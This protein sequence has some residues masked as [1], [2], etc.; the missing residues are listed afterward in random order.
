MIRHWWRTRKIFPTKQAKVLLPAVW[1]PAGVSAPLAGGGEGRLSP[2]GGHPLSSGLCVIAC[3]LCKWRMKTTGCFLFLP[4]NPWTQ[5]TYGSACAGD[6]KERLTL[7]LTA[8]KNQCFSRC[9]LKGT[10]LLREQST[11]RGECRHHASGRSWGLHH[12]VWRRRNLCLFHVQRAGLAVWS[13]L[14][15]NVHQ[16]FKLPLSPKP[17]AEC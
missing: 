15:L 5:W 9:L 6:E 1:E 11:L 4:L 2:C 10:P 7:S 13:S 14:C 17:G 16:I 8:R 3:P 12:W